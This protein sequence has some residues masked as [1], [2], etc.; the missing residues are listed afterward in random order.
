MYQTLIGVKEL[1]AHVKDPEWVIID[2]RFD[3]LDPNWGQNAFSQSHIPGAQFSDLEKN[4]CGTPTSTSGR[5]PFPDLNVFASFLVNLGL[6]ENHQ[7][8]IY[9]QISGAMASRL[10]WML[11]FCGHTKVAVLDGGFQAWI[12]LGY[13]TS[14]EVFSR[15]P[16]NFHCKPD[17]SMHL[18]AEVIQSER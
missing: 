10:W 18:P 2:N 15:P 7:V 3:L 4:V 14:T 1:Y 5:H 13:P 12:T 9:D 6:N 17:P 8:V 11:R 16:G